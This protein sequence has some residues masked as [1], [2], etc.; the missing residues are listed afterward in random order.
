MSKPVFY[1]QPA[2]CQDCNYRRLGCHSECAKYKSWR[3]LRDGWLEKR[4]IAGIEAAD[5]L[6]KSFRKYARGHFSSGSKKT[7]R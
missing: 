1:G 2:P 5:F 6:D 3:A 4:D 7:G